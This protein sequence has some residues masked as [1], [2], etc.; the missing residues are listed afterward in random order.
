[1]GSCCEWIG[2]HNYG[3]EITIDC[4]KGFLK[5]EGIVR[6][7]AKWMPISKALLRSNLLAQHCNHICL[8][9]MLYEDQ[10]YWHCITIMTLPV[11]KAF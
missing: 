5:I 4:V 7:C 8:Y 2:K 1:M 6:T 9:Q 3:S 11:S 10:L